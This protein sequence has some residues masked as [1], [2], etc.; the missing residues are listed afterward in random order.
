MLR[1]WTVRGQVVSSFFGDNVGCNVQKPTSPRRNSCHHEHESVSLAADEATGT[2]GSNE[3]SYEDADE[4]RSGRG[5]FSAQG[6]R[7]HGFHGGCR[8]GAS[9][10]C[11]ERGAVE[12]G[13]QGGGL[14]GGGAV[15]DGR[16]GDGE[17]HL[18]EDRVRNTRGTFFPQPLQTSTIPIPDPTC[19]LLYPRHATVSQCTTYA[20]HCPGSS[21]RQHA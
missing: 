17:M 13:A 7:S 1:C 9:R 21:S 14:K 16:E 6:E 8:G 11:V 10:R 5:Q 20:C 12:G 3:Q 15:R 2:Y 4:Q 19:M 18:S